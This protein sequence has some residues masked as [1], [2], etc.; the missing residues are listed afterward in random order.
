VGILFLVAGKIVEMKDVGQLFAILGKYILCCL[1]GHAIHGLLVLPLIYFIFTRKNPYHFLWGILTP[2]ATAFGT[3]S[4]CASLP[5]AKGRGVGIRRLKSPEILR[6]EFLFHS[7]SNIRD[8]LPPY[9]VPCVSTQ[10]SHL[11][12]LQEHYSSWSQPPRRHLAVIALP[13]TGD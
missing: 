13:H 8:L 11:W 3:S 4:R 12:H 5:Y 10:L 2:L 9:S 7:G 6:W 1:L